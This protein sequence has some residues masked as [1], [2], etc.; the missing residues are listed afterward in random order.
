MMTPPSR[1]TN[2]QDRKHC[3][4]IPADPPTNIHPL[5]I[6]S[7]SL[8]V[9]KLKMAISNKVTHINKIEYIRCF[10][11]DGELVIAYKM[12]GLRLHR[13]HTQ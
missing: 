11:Y 2:P 13:E 12:H 7:Y 10:T 5:L 6:P 3:K 4:E 9:S 8:S 1:A